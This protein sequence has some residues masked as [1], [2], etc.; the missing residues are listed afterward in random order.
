VARKKPRR[1]PRP[2]GHRPYRKMFV[3]AT[4]GEK[5]EPQYFAILNNANSVVHINCI[6]CKHESAPAQV[7]KRMESFLKEKG[8][9]ASDE[10]WLVI[11]KDEWQEEQLAVL[12]DWSLR[13]DNYGLALSNPK[14]EYWL[15]LHFEEGNG[16]GS[17]EACNRRLTY[18][19]PNYDKGINK[20]DISEAQI[21]EAIERARRRDNPPCTD[22]PRS[23]GTT[24]YRLVESIIRV[25]G[26]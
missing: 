4:E 6:R 18:Y 5:T 2:L 1:F 24:V 3:L 16:I 21:H 10:A 25:E 17:G 23:T 9:K 15:L 14:F 11:D 8:L 12:Y 13:K 22:W 20:S 19:L 7:L 26:E